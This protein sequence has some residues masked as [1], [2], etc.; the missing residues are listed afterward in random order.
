MAAG[1]YSRCVAIVASLKSGSE[2]EAY[3]FGPPDVGVGTF[4][5]AT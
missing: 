3:Q 5:T 2:W 1:A 4:L